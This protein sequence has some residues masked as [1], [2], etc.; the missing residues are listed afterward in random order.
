MMW[1]MCTFMLCLLEQLNVK[2]CIARILY[3]VV[4]NTCDKTICCVASLLLL[5]IFGSVYLLFCLFSSFKVRASRKRLPLMITMTDHNLIDF[6][7][8]CRPP[9]LKSQKSSS[10][11]RKRKLRKPPF[12]RSNHPPV[13]QHFFTCTVNMN[14]MLNF[15][16][17]DMTQR[18]HERNTE[19]VLLM[20]SFFLFFL[21]RKRKQFVKYCHHSVPHSEVERQNNLI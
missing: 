9:K 16:V 21:L 17:E 1:V 11:S 18:L 4:S 6:A 7:A 12:S 5:L 3:D 10:S 14:K 8:G 15:N 2:Y 13:K 19:N 20:F